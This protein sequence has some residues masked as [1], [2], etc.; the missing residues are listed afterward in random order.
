MH[1]WEDFC[2]SLCQGT[3]QGGSS[4]LFVTAAAELLGHDRHVGINSSAKTHFDCLVG[5][6]DG[7]EGG[8]RPANLK[9]GIDEV[10]RVRRDGSRLFK[11]FSRNRQV[12]QT[13]LAIDCQAVED[14]T[15]KPHPCRRML[16]VEQRVKYMWF[17]AGVD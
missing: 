7:D 1:C 13:A 4:G 15:V 14:S 11:V 16:L 17:C 6:L 9:R 3:G 8:L 10:F 2:Q 5:L 12:C